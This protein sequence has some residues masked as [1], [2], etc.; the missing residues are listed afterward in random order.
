MKIFREIKTPKYIASILLNK[1][2]VYYELGQYHEALKYYDESLKIFREIKTPQYS[3]I[4]E[5][6]LV[7]GLVYKSL[8]Q[9]QEALKYYDE[10]LKIQ[11]DNLSSGS[12]AAELDYI[13]YVYLALKDYKRAEAL[14]KDA[15]D[16]RTKKGIKKFG[17][18][19]LVELYIAA[20]KDDEAIKLLKEM[21]PRWFDS[22]SDQMLYHTQHGLS[23]KGAKR[24]GEAS[25]E[26]LKAITLTEEIR[27]MVKGEKT[28]FLGA[29]RYSSRIRSYKGL[30][31][32]LS[33]RAIKGERIDNEFTAYGKDLASSAFYFA[34]STKARTLL[35]AMAESAKR[36]ISA[37]LPPEITKK[38]EEILNQLSAIENQWNETYKKGEEAMKR[39]VERKKGL[40]AGLNNLIA[41]LRQ[42]YPRYAAIYYPKPIPPEELPLKEDEVLLEYALGDDAGYLFVVSGTAGPSRGVKRIIK[43]PL[44]REALE[45]KVKSFMEP[46]N[47]RR[48]ERFSINE[49]RGLYDILLSEALKEIDSEERGLKKEA[50]GNKK[51][52]I[53]P[54]GI[55]GLL[56]FE[57]LVIKEGNGI[58]DSLYVGDRYIISYYQ[59]ATVLALKRTTKRDKADK[60][61][62]ALGNPVYSKEDPRYIAWKESA[63]PSGRLDVHDEK[64]KGEL[65]A[66]ASNKYSFRDLA[67]KSKWGKTT[68]ADTTGSKV[69]FT[70]LPETEIE[71]KEIA[72]I[73]DVSPK[74]PDI[75]FSVIANETELKKTGLEKYRYI[76]FATHASLPGMIQGINEPFILLGQVENQDGDDGFL[77]LSEVLN[78]RLNADIVVLSACVTGVGKEVEG[79]G[80]AN[81]ARAFQHAGA[82][83]VVVSLWEV[84]SLEAVEYMKGFYGHLKAGKGRAEALRLARN[85]IKAR[86]PNPFYWA[87]FILHGEG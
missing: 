84:A 28:G 43:I 21:M 76:H 2:V 25:G 87:V 4:S 17:N 59:S 31:S 65:I 41:E 18:S 42:G 29:G 50:G 5:N 34:E 11:R 58:K 79:E 38:E 1:G 73:M 30:M 69:E 63:Q 46:M 70:P 33:E 49:A 24:L 64:E 82:G 36:Y 19:G 62:F 53:V 6:L 68:E 81:F 54:D 14:F 86:Y 16:E 57:A 26:F 40:T 74:P 61:L 72:R 71:I 32:A 67:L 60:A 55:L 7:I 35:E 22:P 3:G 85:E 15:E 75:L 39:L 51:I 47:T 78:L 83:S 10:S 45:E 56:P 27:Q 9:Y 66:S 8:G 44:S 48:R 77:T 52:I 80:V 23:L 20:G 37:G 13:G 12:I